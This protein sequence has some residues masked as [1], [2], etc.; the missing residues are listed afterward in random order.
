MVGYLVLR[1]VISL[2]FYSH[3]E[4]GSYNSLRKLWR[5]CSYYREELKTV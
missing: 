2:K 4:V 5:I 1:A 3:F